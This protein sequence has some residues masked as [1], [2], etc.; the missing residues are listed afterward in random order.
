[1]TSIATPQNK[2][3]VNRAELYYPAV[4]HFVRKHLD[5][6]KHFAARF[7]AIYFITICSEPRGVNQLCR[8]EVVV[9]LFKTA[10]I[11]HKQQRWYLNLLLLMPDHAHLLIGV[12]PDVSLSQLIRDYKRITARLSGVKWQRNFFDHRLRHSESVARKYDYIRQ[13]PVRAGLVADE[14]EWPYLL[15]IADLDGPGSGD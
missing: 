3:P 7:G 2:L 5:H 9:P 11:Y 10:R 6:T 1:L 14:G 15:R 8:R 4:P 12:P 13:N